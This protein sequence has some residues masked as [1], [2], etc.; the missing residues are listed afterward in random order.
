MAFLPTA[1]P[2][3]RLEKH[4]DVLFSK[5]V[6]VVTAGAG[7]GK[8][9]LLRAWAERLA[10]ST[11]VA[12]VALDDRAGDPGVLATL[13]DTALARAGASLGEALR[14]PAGSAAPAPESLARALL[15][16]IVGTTEERGRDVAIFLDDFHI[17]ASSAGVRNLV[18][19]IVRGLPPRA[20]IVIASRF[21]LAFAPLVG[22]RAERLVADFSQD[23]LRFTREE[24]LALFDDAGVRA[25]DP[26]EIASVLTRT[27]GWAM[28]LRLSTQG[29][30]DSTFAWTPASQRSL[31][32]YLADEVLRVQSSAVRTL[33][34]DCAVVSVLDPNTLAHVLD[35]ADGGALVE[36]L[37]ALD[38]YLESSGA[39]T[40]RFHHLFREFLIATFAAEQPERLRALRRRYARY[41]ENRGDLMGAVIAYLEAGDYISAADH[42]AHVQFAIRY[43]DD[44]ERIATIFERIPV[45]LKRERPRLLQL[46]ATARKRLSDIAGA[47]RSFAQACA[48]ALDLAAYGTATVCAIEE[49]MLADDL[50]DGGHGEFKRSLALCTQALDYAKRTG[51]KRATYVKMASLALGLVHAARFEYTLARPY[52]ADAERLQRS[53][54][55]QR[56]DILTTIA[57]IEGWQGRWQR[58]LESAELAEDLFRDGD[59]D[60]LCGRALK[61]QAKAHCFLRDDVVRA[62][63]LAERAVELERDYN[64]FD[65][66][67]DACVILARAHLAQQVPSV[68]GAYAALAAAERYLERWP[69]KVTAF[70]IRTARAET[71]MLARDMAGM[72]RELAAADALAE[73]SG[74]ARAAAFVVFLGGL[75]DA[76]CGAFVEAAER[77][78]RARVLYA[79]I[80][81]AYHAQLADLAACGSL[82]RVDRLDA[83][84]LRELF[85]RLEDAEALHALRAAPRSAQAVV[86]WALRDGSEAERACALLAASAALSGD[87]AIAALAADT[88]APA[89]ARV[90]AIA[91]LGNERREERRVLLSACARQRSTAVAAAATTALALYPHDVAPQLGIDVIGALRVRIG[92]Q[93]LDERNGRW[94][95]R[96]SIEMLR[97]LALAGRPV[98]KA[99]LIASLWPG[100]SASA[101]TSLRVTLHA[102]RRALEPNAEGGEHYIA[103][104]GITLVLRRETIASI[105]AHDALAGVERATFACARGDDAQAEPLYAR[106]VDALASAANIENAPEWL[107]PHVRA[108]RQALV[109]ALRGWAQLRLRTG[110]PAAARGMIE[111]A[112]HVDPLDEESVSVAIDIAL[113][114]GDHGRAK[115]LFVS[116]KQRLRA[117]LSTSPGAELLA[118]YGDVLR[119]R[120]HDRTSEL[121]PREIEILTLI[122][123]GR[124]NKQIAHELGVSAF[125]VGSHVARTLRKLNVDSRAAAIAAAAGLLG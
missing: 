125:T 40:V 81:D 12:W 17:V 94:L 28:A 70:D 38:C 124:S 67:P 10:V 114:T 63:A 65:D 37:R 56:S 20:H 122:G 91:Y 87:D 21:A 64:Q 60:Y 96:K 112:L 88:T 69:N 117:E 103:Y 71:L 44:T 62:L 13:L 92:E 50:R 18:G 68:A 108:W 83:P 57:E 43:G 33:L 48:F 26:S 30:R 105:D 89:T 31:F 45:D 4:A 98:A 86:A 79:A 53:S 77:F 106:A 101:E 24:A 23:D 121:T 111:R 36:R 11:A 119:A 1:V 51:E 104:D 9:T 25:S 85:D 15:D 52:L 8:T 7:Y 95:R 16:E 75:R 14:L 42:V 35:V 41:L 34:L 49:A 76:A 113:A 22:L 58:A 54:P 32:A 100:A 5:R 99:E 3:P 19:L 84:R 118:K 102:L 6:T 72:R 97:L 27:D 2:R 66:L 55:T 116:Y 115:T 82:A 78:E 123:R 73:R 107:E 59:G 74:D 61:V 80:F 93:M 110:T 120:A 109:A 29:H 47:Q 39:D 90:R 46:E